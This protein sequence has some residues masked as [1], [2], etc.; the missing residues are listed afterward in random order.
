MTLLANKRIKAGTHPIPSLLDTGDYTPEVI[1]LNFAL[2]DN[3]VELL[4]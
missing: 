4:V 2:A 3:L 1:Q